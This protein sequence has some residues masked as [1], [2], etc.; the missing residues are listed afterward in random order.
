VEQPQPDL[1]AL[2]LPVR[3]QHYPS[4]TPW[5][6]YLYGYTAL[7]A[8]LELVFILVAIQANDALH[9]SIPST[10]ILGSAG[11][12]NNVYELASAKRIIHWRGIPS[13]APMLIHQKVSFET[14]RQQMQA[15]LCV[16]AAKTGLPLYDL[17]VEK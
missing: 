13:S 14:Y 7:I 16:I 1:G 8:L 9:A 17:R 11:R 2:S 12:S 10:S 3:I 6:W 4:N 5:M 15:L